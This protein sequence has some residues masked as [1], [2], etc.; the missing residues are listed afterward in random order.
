MNG[1]CFIKNNSIWYKAEYNNGK[2]NGYTLCYINGNIGKVEK[3]MDDI[4]TCEW[5]DLKSFKRDNN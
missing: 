2:K 4:K 5:T 3:Y 1:G